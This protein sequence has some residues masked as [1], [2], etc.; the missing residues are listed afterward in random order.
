[1]YAPGTRYAFNDLVYHTPG[2]RWGGIGVSPGYINLS[3][4]TAERFM[5]D[6]FVGGDGRMFRT[7]D[8]G[9]LLPNGKY[10][11]LGREDSQ[12]KLK[13]YRIELDEVAE[14]MMQHPFITSAAAIVKDKTHLVGYFAP[15]SINIQEL[16]DIVA[17][18]LPVYMVPAVWVG[19]E[20]MPQN[21]NGKIDKKALEL[22]DVNVNVTTLETETEK[23][24]ASIWSDVLNVDVNAIGRH[25]SFF[26]LGGDSISVIKVVAA[27]KRAGLHI[28]AAAFLKGSILSRVALAM[29]E[30][31]QTS[32]P[33]VTVHQDVLN[34]VRDDW[35][36]I[37]GLDSYNVCPVTPLQGGMIY[38]TV[39]SRDAYIAQHT[40]LLEGNTEQKQLSSAYMTLVEA[41]DIL[42]TTFVTTT[43]GIYQV[44]R[45]DIEHLEVARVSVSTIDEFL[46]TDHARGFE[47]GDKYFIRLTLVETIDQYFG[48]LTMHHALYDG[49][50]I[51]MVMNDLVDILRGKAVVDRPS[52]RSVVDY[53]EAQDKDETEA[54]W[55]SYL[56]SI[57]AL[58]IRSSGARLNNLNEE[59]KEPLT[60]S[61]SSSF[62][63]VTAV[64]QRAGVTAAELTKLAW[65]ATLRKYTRQN[66]V[67][68]GQ[69][70]ANRDIPVKDADRIMGPLLSTVPCRVLFNDTDTLPA[71]VVALQT[72]RGTTMRHSHASLVDMKRWIGSAGELFDTLFVYQN[73]PHE[74][75]STKMDGFCIVEPTEFSNQST[76]FAL[77]LMVVPNA[78]NLNVSVLYNPTLLSWN[79][80]C[81][82]MHEFDHTVAQLCEGLESSATVSTLWQLSPSQTTVIETSSFGPQVNLPYG[83]VHQAFEENATTNPDQRAVEFGN[84]WLSY[85]E[86]NAHANSLASDLT[87]MG[88]CLGDRV[89]VLMDRCLEF[90]VGMLAVLK[91]GAVMMPLDASFPSKRIQHMMTEANVVMVIATKDQRSLVH[92]LELSIPVVEISS[93]DVAL[94]SNTF[95]PSVQASRHD[96]AYIVYTSGS[97]GKPKGIPVL[98]ESAVNAIFSAFG[99]FDIEE[100]MRVMQFRA[101]ASDVFEWELWKTLS[102]GACVVFR[103]E[104]ALDTLLK[105][106]VLSSTPT[107]LSLFG[108]PSQYPNLKCVAVGGESL[109]ASLKDLWCDYVR[110]INCYGPS[111]C[112]IRTHEYELFRDVPVTIGKPMNNASCYV[113][114]GNQRRVPVGVVGEIYLGGIC[115]SPGYIN[116]PDQTSERFLADPFVSGTGRMYRTG[117]QRRLLPNGDF[118]ILGRNDSQVKLK[119]YRI[120]LDE[121]ADAM[122][123]HP[124]VVSAAVI[125]KD[126]THLV[127]YFSPADVNVQDLEQTVADHLPVYMVPA[128]WVGLDVMPQN[129][130]GKIDKNALEL[131]DVIKEVEEFETE[132][133]K[134]L[135]QIWAEILNIEMS[136]I[137]RNT[138]FFAVGGNSISVVKVV[139]ACRK[140]GL[141]ITVAQF[142]KAANLWRVA[143]ALQSK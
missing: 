128:V 39:N 65:A 51:S 10:E 37:L 54:Y 111:E 87:N 103:G 140:R 80:A 50:S 47:I 127:G 7:G 34:S 31:A 15:K 136:C 105:V 64:A 101:I 117:D 77:E 74:S 6:P 20:E 88:V 135:A 118:E 114:D 22:L 137:S 86:V 76:E 42:R 52:F 97:T 19:L 93:K 11:I 112:A 120:E 106:D 2:G 41:R 89:A 110:L 134:Q 96:E 53:I 122:M 123:Q 17:S 12:V 124:G 84:E 58:P 56:S 91:V 36:E 113:L 33:R 9:R 132:T 13:G 59:S 14:A 108:H 48:V 100:G 95:V 141:H 115:V 68:F 3:E 107:G 71:A 98:H 83:L 60:K 99:G 92:E 25:T 102:C 28:S 5:K 35:M 72:E 8:L 46:E 18:H 57:G 23:L 16:E 1:M 81:L 116:L 109:P 63:Y 67:V 69:V 61:A 24:L 82:I 49:W 139:S 32:W 38:A 21:T 27:C 142:V 119:G 66:D 90:P 133:E 126:N 75:K 29:A 131:L 85:G 40:M 94:H 55:R 30:P 104:D 125:V 44:I 43:S 121:V 70:M 143:A 79:Q 73:L 4:Q 78:S 45:D 62:A 130:G 138:S 129:T 26:A